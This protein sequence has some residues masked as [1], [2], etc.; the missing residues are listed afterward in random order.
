MDHFATVD[1]VVA[2]SGARIFDGRQTLVD[3]AVLVEGGI[4]SAVVP[5][6][7]VGET[8]THYREQDCTVLP[9]LIDTHVHF[10]RWQGPQFLAFGV[11]TVRDTGNPLKWILDRRAVRPRAVVV[12]A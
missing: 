2:Y 12:Q 3:H 7:S 6:D 5:C 11:T 4:V 8:V 10:M 1:G 9:G